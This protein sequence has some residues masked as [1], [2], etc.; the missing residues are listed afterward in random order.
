MALSSP[1]RIARNKVTK[2]IAN[3]TSGMRLPGQRKNA[4]IAATDR[5]L[6][7]GADTDFRAIIPTWKRPDPESDGVARPA[8]R[9]ASIPLSAARR[10]L[11]PEIEA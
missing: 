2:A 7:G 1:Q 9:K 3:P 4:T 8:G 6:I 10:V 11:W 5:S